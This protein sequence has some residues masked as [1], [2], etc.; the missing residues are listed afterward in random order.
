[1]LVNLL[2]AHLGTAPGRTSG[3][4]KLADFL[5]DRQVSSHQQVWRMWSEG[6]TGACF[7]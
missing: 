7:K 5:A 2:D 1:M 3:R 4:L 6:A